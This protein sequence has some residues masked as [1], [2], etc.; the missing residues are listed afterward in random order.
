M[1]SFASP[2][3]LSTNRLNKALTSL[4]ALE[5]SKTELSG[6]APAPAPA[7]AGPNPPSIDYCNPA[8]Y[9]PEIN[10]LFSPINFIDFKKSD[11]K[12]DY[13]N[14]SERFKTLVNQIIDPYCKDTSNPKKIKS[15]NSFDT[16]IQG[17]NN[18]TSNDYKFVGKFN[19]ILTSKKSEFYDSPVFGFVK[20]VFNNLVNNDPI[21][22]EIDSYF[23]AGSPPPDKLDPKIK[24]EIVKALTEDLPIIEKTIGGIQQTN[25]S[26][27][28]LAENIKKIKND[29]TKDQLT[30]L[31]NENTVIIEKTLKDKNIIVFG[32]INL[33][34]IFKNGLIAAMKF[35]TKGGARQIR[36]KTRKSPS[37]HRR[38]TRK[39]RK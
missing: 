36:M 21:K 1:F 16:F 6:P 2:V 23:T 8:N 14:I 3:Y 33:I 32:G 22:K 18:L 10:K 38:M 12:T 28:K 20:D 37:F 11:D 5:K 25:I 35:P 31:I 15:E 29:I 17:K 27:D 39:S 24:G 30:N 9:N 19:E 4:D 26:F 34:T 7:P 13:S